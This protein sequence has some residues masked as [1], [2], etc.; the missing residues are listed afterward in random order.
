MQLGSFSEHTECAADAAEAA[1]A[2]VAGTDELRKFTETE[3]GICKVVAMAAVVEL[4]ME[5]II[6]QR[7]EVRS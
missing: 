5:K 7:S 1:E 2:A 3:A 6:R 4:D